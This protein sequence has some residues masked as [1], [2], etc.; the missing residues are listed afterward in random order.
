MIGLEIA[1]IVG[2]IAFALS[3]F[4]VATRD[5]LDLLGIF[6][7]SFL[8]A[9]GG[10]ILRDTVADRTPFAFSHHTPTL[11]VILVILIA[12]VFKFYK[13]NRIENTKIF[14]ISD[15]IGLVSF[16]ITGALVGLMVD[17]NVFGVVMLALSTAVGGGIMRDMLLNRVPVVLTSELYGTIAIVI[18]FVIYILDILNEIHNRS[19]LLVFGVGLLIR[20]VAY[21]RK[22]SLPKLG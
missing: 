18:G 2:T 11:L 22:W 14:V 12:V 21:Y 7:A 13:K 9:L 20:L 19:L 10:G 5:R 8:T 17:F 4:M 15:S 6:I 1:D 16:S 3:G